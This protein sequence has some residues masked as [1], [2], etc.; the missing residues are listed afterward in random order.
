MENF[1]R[2]N[3]EVGSFS[4]VDAVANGDDGV[5]VVGFDGTGNLTFAFGLNL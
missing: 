2:P 4:R 5:E 3:A 1:G